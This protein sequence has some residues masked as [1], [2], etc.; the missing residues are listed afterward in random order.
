MPW[1]GMTFAVHDG[2]EFKQFVITANMLGP[3][4]WA[5]I[6]TQQKGFFTLR[7]E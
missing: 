4:A 5:N 1:V 3:Q 2:K 7:Q 6:H